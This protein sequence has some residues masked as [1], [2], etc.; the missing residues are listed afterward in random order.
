MYLQFFS[1]IPAL[2]AN[3][4][5]KTI[6]ELHFNMFYQ[7]EQ[8]LR[9]KGIHHELIVRHAPQQNGVAE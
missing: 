7:F 5:G 2:I 1:E 9:S 4:T 8:Y 6:G 3:T